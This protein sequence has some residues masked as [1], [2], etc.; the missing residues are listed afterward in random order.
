MKAIA[1]AARHNLLLERRGLEGRN[2]VA[3]TNE[4]WSLMRG[5]E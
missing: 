3:L 2:Y 5:L 1:R 4:D